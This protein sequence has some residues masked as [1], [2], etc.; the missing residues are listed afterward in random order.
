MHCKNR[1]QNISKISENFVPKLYVLST[2]YVVIYVVSFLNALLK[3]AEVCTLNCFSRS[4]F[5]FYKNVRRENDLYKIYE[6]KCRKA[7]K[8][9]IMWPHTTTIFVPMVELSNCVAHQCQRVIQRSHRTNAQHIQPDRGYR[10]LVDT[11]QN[12]HQLHKIWE[13]RTAGRPRTPFHANS[14]I[15][16]SK[17]IL[18]RARIKEIE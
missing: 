18:T 1:H 10:L 2:Y 6:W 14:E 7:S 4:S 11:R 12:Q 13:T 3:N 5:L 9:S 16:K 8:G 17:T 15:I